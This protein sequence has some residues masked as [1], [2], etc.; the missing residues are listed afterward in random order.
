MARCALMTCAD[1]GPAARL[2]SNSPSPFHIP[3][4][5]NSNHAQCG[6]ITCN[7][8]FHTSGPN[9]CS[10]GREGE[11][12]EVR[13]SIWWVSAA[14]PPV[15]VTGSWCRLPPPP[16]LSPPVK[17]LPRWKDQGG[18]MGAERSPSLG[19]VAGPVFL[20]ASAQMCM[21]EMTIRGTTNEAAGPWRGDMCSNLRLKRK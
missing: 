16:A 11:R 20:P 10:W 8:S 18:P 7:Y 2:G 14:I 9:L 3:A 5:P 21:G 6:G 12:R 17:P 13:A 4:L 1:V 19:P 15:C